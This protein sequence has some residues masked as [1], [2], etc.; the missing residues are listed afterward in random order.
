LNWIVVLVVEV[1]LAGVGALKVNVGT[2]VSMV[3]V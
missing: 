1:A 2:V 3:S